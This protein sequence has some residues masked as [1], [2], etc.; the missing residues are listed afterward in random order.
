MKESTEKRAEVV[1]TLPSALFP[2]A[3]A[4]LEVSALIIGKLVLLGLI[5]AGCGPPI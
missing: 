2:S 1:A 5:T 3:P 4:A